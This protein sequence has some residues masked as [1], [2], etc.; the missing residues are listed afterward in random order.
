MNASTG[1]PK[2]FHVDR[3]NLRLTPKAWRYA[4]ERRARIDEFF[5]EQMRQ[6]PSL[7]NGRVLMMHRYTVS[8]G[9]FDGDY[10]ETDYASLSA[11]CSWGREAAEVSDCFGAAPLLSADG[12]FLLGRMGPHTFNAG[13]VYFASGTPDR[14]DIVGD[15]VDMDFNIRREL[16]E[17]TGLDITEFSE[18]PGWTTV[19]DGSLIAHMKVLRSSQSAAVL[20]ARIL[21]ELRREAE[22]ELSD[23]VIVRSVADMTDAMPRY[24]R[25]FLA[26][27]FGRE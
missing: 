15:M 14:S 8:D 22:P 27:R 4:D 2:I 21:D 10:L 1:A 17:E 11:W 5:A 25:A 16:K 9:V 23:I 20:R 24:V 6:K 7:W 19:I 12:A 3:L 26:Q 18:E 13:Q